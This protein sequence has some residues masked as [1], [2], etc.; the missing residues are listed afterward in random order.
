MV[1]SSLDVVRILCLFFCGPMILVECIMSIA[2]YSNIV[3]DCSKDL[4]DGFTNVLIYVLI[5]AGCI[6]VTVTIFCFYSSYMIAK[7]V[8]ENW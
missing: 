7:I 4:P 8:K 2:F 6:S 5:I 3:N 1:E